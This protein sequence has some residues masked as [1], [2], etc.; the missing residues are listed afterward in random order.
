M[1]LVNYGW[2]IFFAMILL[3]LAL[4]FLLAY[5]RWSEDVARTRRERMRQRWHQ[6][7]AAQEEEY[8]LSLRFF[9]QLKMIQRSFDDISV[10]TK[11]A[12]RSMA[13]FGDKMKIFNG[14]I[15]L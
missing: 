8:L 1:S 12:I 4:E 7:E 11:E 10:V 13:K 5:A 14:E 6:Y 2:I 15:K 9:F 3:L